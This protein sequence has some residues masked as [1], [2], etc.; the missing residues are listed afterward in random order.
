VH[1]GEDRVLSEMFHKEIW[2]G[3]SNLQSLRGR[4]VEP[5]EWP[6]FLVPGWICAC[7]L[8]AL[9]SLASSAA[10]P[11]L[12]AALAGLLPFSA[13]VLRLY[14]LGGL[15]IALAHIVAFYGYYFPAR[16]WGTLL[17]A[18]RTLGHRLHAH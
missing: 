2:R 15:R 9:L 1:L 18:F 3:Q 16:A 5:G 12:A 17:G 8:V 13:Y 7:L 6:S 14:F 10:L 11:A 4:R